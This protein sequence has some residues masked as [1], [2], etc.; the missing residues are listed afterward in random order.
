M[1]AQPFLSS[2]ERE[3]RDATFAV[4]VK[5]AKTT[6]MKVALVL[7]LEELEAADETRRKRWWWRNA[8]RKHAPVLSGGDGT[9]R[10]PKLYGRHSNYGRLHTPKLSS[11]EFYE[12]FRFARED[13]P[14]LVLALRMPRQLRTMSGCVMDGEEAL[15]LFLRVR[16]FYPCFLV[17]S[18][19]HA[20]TSFT[21]HGLSEPPRGFGALLPAGL[22][23]HLGD[24]GGGPTTSGQECS[25]F[26]AQVRP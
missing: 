4:A 23:L 1:A 15:L 26:S 6:I 11:K 22:W 19:S 3:E 21:A 13:I 17:E 10:F 9:H 2:H 25:S 16:F 12:H 14:R 5:R 20:C 8:L 7:T 24:G 18:F